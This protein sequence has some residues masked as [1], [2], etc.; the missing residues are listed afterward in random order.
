MSLFLLKRS[1]IFFITILHVVLINVST[2]WCISINEIHQLYQNK[3][4]LTE[5]QWKEY[6]Q[7]LLG[8]RIT[9]TGRVLQVEEKGWI[10]KKALIHLT[11]E[12]NNIKYFAACLATK[13]VGLKIVKNNIYSITGS[14]DSIKYKRVVSLS[15][16][17]SW[18]CVPM[19]PLLNA[20]KLL[21][22]KP[23]SGYFMELRDSRF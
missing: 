23:V 20:Y 15:D 16:I 14:I 12:D 18:L 17:I 7:G 3:N 1:C 13:K 2:G 11:G 22:D 8:K 21:D 19:S 4:N 5:I 9:L 10:W 6:H